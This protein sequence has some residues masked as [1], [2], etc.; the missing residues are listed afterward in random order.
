M[1]VHGAGLRDRSRFNYWGRIPRALEDRGARVFFGFQDGWG[2]VEYNADF[3][4]GSLTTI[5]GETESEKVNIIAHS[6]GGLDCRH[7]ISSLGMADKVASLTTV[8]TPHHG[9]K[10]ISRLCRLPVWIFKLVALFANFF[11]R[12]TGDKNPDFFSVSRQFS[13][14]SMEAF[15]ARNPDIPSVY[16][17][18]Y[19]A[20]MKGP[21]SDIFML[22]TNG[23]VGL[24]DGEN[25]GLFTPKSVAWTNFKGVL[26]RQTRRGISHLDMV[27]FR[28]KNL[29][30]KTT[31]KGEDEAFDIREFYLGVVS[32]LKRMGF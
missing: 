24:N 14:A 18:S 20:L 25:D 32:D 6:K 2:S 3:L 30:G 23:F 7:M 17:Q 15:N 10:T 4:K 21:L 9:S 31:S 5:L 19:A 13:T 26:A 8:C 27:D 28:R 16:Y 29:A 22:A 11:T 12:L 1:L